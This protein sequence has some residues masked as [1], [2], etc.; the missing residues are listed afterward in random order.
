MVLAV[1]LM[2]TATAWAQ[3]VQFPIYEGDKGTEAK[4]YQIKTAADL[5]KLSD[6]VNSGTTYDGVYFKL[7]NDINF[8]EA[9]TTSLRPTTAWNAA[10]STES[11][12]TPIGSRSES[13][14]HKFHGH[15]DGNDCTISG[16]RIYNAGPSANNGGHQG[17]FGYLGSGAEVKAVTLSN[18]RITGHSYTG[19]IVGRNE[20]N[21]TVSDCHVTNTVAIHTAKDNVDYHGGIIG[22]NY[23]GTVKECTSAA[24]LTFASTNYTGCEGYGGIVGFNNGTLTDNIAN[25]ATVPAASNEN[26][27][28]AIAG[29]GYTTAM[30][31]NYYLNCN[32]AGTANATG[33]GM[34]GAD[35]T[36]NNASVSIHTL[37]L[38][39]GV[40]TTTS[41]SVNLGGTGYYAQGTALVLNNGQSA[42]PTGYT[43]AFTV[44]GESVATTDTTGAMPAADDLLA[45][46]VNN[47]DGHF[48]YNT[49]FKL[50]D[51]IAYDYD[52]AWD[53]ATSYASNFTP[54][55]TNNTYF[56]GHFDGNGKTISGIRVYAP[57]TN[58]IAIFRTIDSQAEVKGITLDDTRLTGQN[59]VAGIVACT[60]TNNGTGTVTGC[61]VTNRVAIHITATN[62]S[63]YGGIVAVNNHGTVSH[64]VS[65]I[66][67]TIADGVTPRYCGGI[68]GNNSD[69][70][71]DNFV[72]GALIPE[73]RNSAH[74]AIAVN[75]YNT[76]S[77]SYAHNY[78]LNCSVAGTANATGVGVCTMVNETT[79]TITDITE[80]NGAVSV[81]TLTL[82]DGITATPVAITYG[83][84]DY[85][86]Q[87]STL[88]LSGGPLD[89]DGAPKGLVPGYTANGVLITPANPYVY[90]MP[91]TD[92]VTIA[93][94]SDYVPIPDWATVSTGGSDDPYLIYCKEQLDLLAQRVNDGTST[95]ENK[96]FKLAA[97]ITYPHTTAWNDATSEENNYTAIGK[98]DFNFCGHFL[99]DGHT[100]SGI[101]ICQKGNNNQGLFG[102]ING[103]ADV[104][105]VTLTDTR[106]TGKDYVGGIVGYNHSSSVTD[107]HATAT[108]AIHAA[109]NEAS[110]H[111]GIVGYNMGS[112]VSRCTSAAT[113]TIKSGASNC[114]YYSGIVGNNFGNATLSH[115]LAI[116]A[117]VPA[118]YN[119]GAITGEKPA[120]FLHNYYVGCTV[121]DATTNIGC[122]KGNNHSDI[123][124]NDGAVPAIGLY[125]NGTANA[126]TISDNSG[127]TRN[128]ALVGRT[129]MDNG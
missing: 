63:N 4:P 30:Q 123:T 82:G 77:Y 128:V 110:H 40:T 60:G 32:V 124:E 10:A 107:C 14:I 27:H 61:T 111:G 7:M 51:D 36:A 59:V 83:G 52:T 26:K 13:T 85:Y 31:R 55:G 81:H 28:G 119:S 69:A 105:G 74:A 24:T 9:S 6:D 25:G 70:L 97:D 8:S 16:I 12:F 46:N 33:V 120:T 95:Y 98:Q 94:T 87:G 37:T 47:D 43:Y 92:D 96:Y 125:D 116:G 11:N 102:N 20:A 112:T 50:G 115:N 41:P 15:F 45:T 5:V 29:D 90:T 35:A 104:N 88:T 34:K 118:T 75:A 66:Q 68:V 126:T 127:Q 48:Y 80:N 56:R 101:R 113:L 76:N 129:Q 121:G 89:P 53:D 58:D 122:G 44:N 73:A 79:T 72:I 117:T 78:Y 42:A 21:T 106:I 71:T 19:G 2:T 22:F 3:T 1:V 86:A 93:A 114:S 84:T 64:C 38:T 67:M 39:G 17:L 62:G 109:V 108:V 49:Y 23:R 54:I 99:G 91:A 57:T 103:G 18:A 65:S 100:I